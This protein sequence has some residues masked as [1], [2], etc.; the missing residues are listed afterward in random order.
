MRNSYTVMQISP[1]QVPAISILTNGSFEGPY[2]KPTR[3]ILGK[4]CI[5]KGRR[6]GIAE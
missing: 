4:N 1:L 2:Q 5:T 3:S 6:E